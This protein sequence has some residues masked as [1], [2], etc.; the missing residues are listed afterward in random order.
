[1]AAY[2]FRIFHDD[3]SAPIWHGVAFAQNLVELF[4]AIDHHADPFGCEFA[5]IPAR[6]SMSICFK[7]DMDEKDGDEDEFVTPLHDEDT[8]FEGGVFEYGFTGLRWKRFPGS[9]LDKVYSGFKKQG[10]SDENQPTEHHQHSG[11]QRA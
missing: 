5:R 2:A 8:E 6:Q 11:S 4:W 3:G 10:A 7:R 1:M 9:F